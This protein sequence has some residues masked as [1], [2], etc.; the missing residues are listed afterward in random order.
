MIDKKKH[1]FRISIIAKQNWLYSI[2]LLLNVTMCLHLWLIFNHFSK[3]L[4]HILASLS[5]KEPKKKIKLLIQTIQSAPKN[6]TKYCF[7]SIWQSLLLLS[8]IIIIINKVFVNSKFEF[9]KNYRIIDWIKKKI[10][11]K[12]R[13]Q[14]NS[15]QL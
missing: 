12:K 11:F 8:V 3:I 14:S 2:N 5:N 1:S 6:A 10:W 13:E 4:F 9:N 7:I 15:N